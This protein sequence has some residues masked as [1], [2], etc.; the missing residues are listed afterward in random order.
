M[1]IV[2]LVLLLFG[3]LDLLTGFFSHKIGKYLYVDVL[4]QKVQEPPHKG[5]V[6]LFRL[7]GFLV[8]LAIVILATRLV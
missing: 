3:G 1:D 5:E 4:K 2:L 6:F 7:I 8:L